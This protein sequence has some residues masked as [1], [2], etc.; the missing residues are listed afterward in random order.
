MVF[1]VEEIRPD[2]GKYYSKSNTLSLSEVSITSKEEFLWVCPRC[3][4]DFSKKLNLMLK[5]KNSYCKTCNAAMSKFTISLKEKYPEVAKMYDEGENDIPSNMIS[6]N[7]KGN[8][9]FLCRNMGEPHIFTSSL[10]LAVRGYYNYRSK[11]CP[12]CAGKYIVAGVNDLK[13]QEPELVK[14]YSVFKE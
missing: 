10:N 11:G 5:A 9:K 14:M 8:F 6:P 7:S 1:S 12:I 4:K 3:G 13:S 2:L